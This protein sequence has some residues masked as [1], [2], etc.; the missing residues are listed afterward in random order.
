M[1]MMMA[2]TLQLDDTLGLLT[3]DPLYLIKPGLGRVLAGREKIPETVYALVEP[4]VGFRLA[5][6]SV[7]VSGLLSLGGGQARASSGRG[8]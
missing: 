3:T 7:G 2:D 6:L 8:C 4:L 5:R 1:T